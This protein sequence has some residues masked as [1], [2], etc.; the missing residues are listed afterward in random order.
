MLSK[1][2][3]KLHGISDQMDLIK[4]SFSPNHATAVPCNRPGKLKCRHHSESPFE[5]LQSSQVKHFTEQ[6]E[7]NF[8]VTLC[9]TPKLAVAVNFAQLVALASHS[10]LSLEDEK[11]K[12]MYSASYSLFLSLQTGFHSAKDCFRTRKQLQKARGL[13][14]LLL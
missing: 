2:C 14:T 1:T 10:K 7:T 13:T 9:I 6:R 3:H 11:R 12:V 4:H 5:C 8:N